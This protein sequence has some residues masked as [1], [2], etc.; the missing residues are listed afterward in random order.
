MQA[1][2]ILGGGGGGGITFLLS[3]CESRSGTYAREYPCGWT[4]GAM[5]SQSKPKII[6]GA[7][8]EYGIFLDHNEERILPDMELFCIERM[9]DECGRS[10]V[11]FGG[12]RDVIRNMKEHSRIEEEASERRRMFTET[13]QST[14][15]RSISSSRASKQRSGE[16]GI[17]ISNGARFYRDMSHPEYSTPETTNP[18]D[19]VVA[20]RAGDKIVE[21]CRARVEDTV[22]KEY[23]TA[24][25]FIHKNNSD[26]RE[27]SYGGHENYSVTLDVFKSI[28]DD[29]REY[30]RERRGRGS[31]AYVAGVV[32]ELIFLFFVARQVIIGSG[33]VGSESGL[34]VPYQISQRSDFF[35][36]R[37]SWTTTHE[38]GII[39]LRNI[40]YAGDAFL[41]RFHVILGDS[42]MSELSIYLKHGITGIF[43]M[44]LNTGFL[45][46]QC[47]GIFSPLTDPVRAL[48]TVSRDLSLERKL[49]LLDGRRM[50]AL[51]IMKLF[52]QCATKFLSLH[53]LPAVWTD[54]VHKWDGVLEGLSG[55]RHKHPLSRS[56]DWVAKE[57]LIN[58]VVRQ[59]EVDPL[60]EECTS[61]AL[62]YHNLNPEQGIFYRLEK[63]GDI[64][65]LSNDADVER[66]LTEA[67]RDTRAWFRSELIKRYPDHIESIGWKSVKFMTKE[68]F[69]VIEFPN[70]L[71]GG[72]GDAEE[73][74]RDN[75]PLHVLIL[76]LLSLDAEDVVVSLYQRHGYTEGES[77][78]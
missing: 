77:D 66:A 42:N 46:E 36:R 6:L 51:E 62:E 69:A 73:L 2:F 33:K 47:S 41:R 32:T 20:E 26:G 54:V 58:A 45:Q 67:P 55:E 23:A 17:K 43:F 8:T 11:S 71:W 65:R 37:F 9:L 24:S 70:P 31:R 76:R 64:L 18:Y 15:E 29:G 61:V 52:A 21:E 10:Y 75:P 68:F 4:E 14:L 56:L 72:P 7:E 44:M 74:L 22:R 12:V 48:H 63:R 35:S 40:P 3:L 16:S 5:D 25:L 28:M 57:R 1:G 78:A 49:P 19:I 30:D 60:S 34:T 50:S 59:R 27:T 13:V 39:N 38:R 53:E